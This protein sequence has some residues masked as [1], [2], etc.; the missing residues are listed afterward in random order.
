MRRARVEERT[1]QLRN[2]SPEVVC[3]LLRSPRTWATVL[4]LTS[5]DT[6]IRLAIYIAYDN[7]DHRAGIPRPA[8]AGAA[9]TARVRHRRVGPRAVRPVSYTHL[10]A[11]E[12]D[13]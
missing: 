2:L 12:T 4:G 3:V 11:H 5:L 1:H 8:L 6:T 7:A 9:A 10:R 13:S